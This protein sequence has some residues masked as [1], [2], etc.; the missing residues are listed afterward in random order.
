MRSCITLLCLCFVTSAFGQDLEYRW[1]PGQ[2]FSYDVK[3]VVDAIDEVVT[4]QG[5]TH[6]TVVDLGPNQSTVTYRGGLTESKRGKNTGG[7]RAPFGP[8]GPRGFGGPPSP[9]SRPAFAGKTQTT[10]KITITTRGEVLAMEGDSQLPYLLGNVSLLPFELLP[11]GEQ[12][13]WE[14]DLGISITKREQS[15]SPFGS[16]GPRGPFGPLGQGNKE[17]VQAAGERTTYQLAKGKGKQTL[18][19]K[20]YQLSTPKSN[21]NRT[22]NIQGKGTWTF[23]QKDNVPQ[24]SSMQMVLTVT[25][26][27]QTNRIPITI[28][29]SRVS[30]ERLAEMQAEAAKRAAEAARIAAEKKAFAEKPLTA[31]EKSDVL[32]KLGKGT[33]AQRVDVLNQL[34]LKSLADP[35]PEIATA[36]NGLIK[37]PQKAVATAAD[38]AF[39]QWSPEYAK[40]MKLAKSYQGPSPVGSTGL[41][42]ESTTPLYVGQLVQAQ[43]PRRGSFWRAAR[44][45]ELLPDG[46]VKLAF[47][48]WGKENE[49]DTVAVARRM[50]QLAPP[51]LEQPAAP[52]VMPTAIVPKAAMRT[53][54][55]ATGRF[56][57]EAEFI[58]LEDG[59]VRLRRADGKL[60]SPL[61]LEKLSE[62]DRA[63]VE[64]LQAADENPF[65]VE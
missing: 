56:K 39:R 32:A 40:R 57:I 5:M 15:N 21:E 41:A 51:E 42:V 28:E 23:D 64:Q 24:S 16:F 34:A 58:S 8:F 60:L 20:T 17:S 45:K 43:R 6:Y 7:N 33:E 13:T 47:L 18:V 59:K 46:Q 62:A 31:D 22:Y 30:A 52:A 54:S 49:R 37:H 1:R 48:T 44:V 61:P 55:D 65:Q 27:N 29:Y 38:K 63:F 4:Y 2:K 36:I 3:I 25:S 9:F 10:N 35:D 50:I 26:G 53:W 11:E 19:N 14:D 12:R